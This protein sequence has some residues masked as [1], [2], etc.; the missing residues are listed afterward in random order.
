MQRRET[1]TEPDIQ[2]YIERIV[3]VLGLGFRI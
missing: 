1:N 3:C 2:I